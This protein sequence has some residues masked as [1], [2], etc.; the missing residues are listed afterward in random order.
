MY[1]K[2]ILSGFGI[3][4]CFVDEQEAINKKEEG[5]Q[6]MNELESIL[7]KKELYSVGEIGLDFRKDVL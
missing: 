2:V 6:W 1:E 7:K 4:P 5:Y 3:H